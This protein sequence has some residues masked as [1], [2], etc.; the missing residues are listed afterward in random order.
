M[1][2]DNIIL[3]HKYNHER[4]LTRCILGRH[5]SGVLREVVANP[6]TVMSQNIECPREEFAYDI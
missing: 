5:S 6:R 4:L 2:F 3:V 1:K